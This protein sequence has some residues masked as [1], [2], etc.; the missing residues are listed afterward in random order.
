MSINKEAISLRLDELIKL[1]QT[2]NAGTIEVG[3]V[4]SGTIS[5]LEKLYGSYSEQLKAYNQMYQGYLRDPHKLAS[6]VEYNILCTTLG[7]LKSIKSEVEAGLVGNL[8]LQ[9]QGGTKATG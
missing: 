3:E 6:S 9:A 7:V 4:T 8:K 2:R 5:I 1:A